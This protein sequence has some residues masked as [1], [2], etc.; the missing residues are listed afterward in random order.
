MTKLFLNAAEMVIDLVQT[1]AASTGR[2]RKK[3]EGMKRVAGGIA[4]GTLAR[5]MIHAL[6]RQTTRETRLVLP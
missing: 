2:H 3:R 5:A 6:F 4:T 1:T